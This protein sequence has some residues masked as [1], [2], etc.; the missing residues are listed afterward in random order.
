[1]NGIEIITTNEY[2]LCPHCEKEL[3]ILLKNVEF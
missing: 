2:P 3:K 1:M